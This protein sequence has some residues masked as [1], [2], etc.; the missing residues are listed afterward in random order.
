MRTSWG[1]ERV[2]F[3]ID[4]GEVRALPIGWTDAG[5]QDPFAAAAG[6]RSCLRVAELL[7][8]VE[9]MSARRR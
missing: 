5:A 9:L 7:A 8:M 1:E 3:K 4:N 6:E 2:Y